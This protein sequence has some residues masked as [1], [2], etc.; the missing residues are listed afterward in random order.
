MT[1]SPDGS[2]VALRRQ[3]THIHDTRSGR[4]VANLSGSFTE[5]LTAAFSPDGRCLA[6]ASG[7]DGGIQVYDTA[8]WRR[9]VTVAFDGG[10]IGVVGFSHDGNSLRARMSSLVDQN[11]VDKLRS[12]HVPSWEEIAKAQAA[13]KQAP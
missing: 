5:T 11:W 1:F 3:T 6:V 7:E 10:M 12:W 2:L 9:L 4:Q 8:T 13:E